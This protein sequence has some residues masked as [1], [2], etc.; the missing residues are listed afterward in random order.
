MTTSELAKLGQSILKGTQIMDRLAKALSAHDYEA[1][2]DL[3]NY[4]NILSM[5]PAQRL[6]LQKWF[7]EQH[8]AVKFQIQESM[9]GAAI[10]LVAIDIAAKARYDALPKPYTAADVWQTIH[11]KYGVITDAIF[12]TDPKQRL[13]EAEYAQMVALYGKMAKALLNHK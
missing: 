8:P 10:D 12:H 4:A 9:D 7:H 6:A 11:D 13:T 1:R 5:T 3:D 2:A